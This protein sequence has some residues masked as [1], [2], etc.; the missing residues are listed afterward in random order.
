MLLK[1]KDRIYLKEDKKASDAPTSIEIAMNE[2]RD[3]LKNIDFTQ[4]DYRVTS[5]GEDEMNQEEEE[6]EDEDVVSSPR[7]SIAV[8]SDS[9]S[10]Q[11][12]QS[13][14]SLSSSSSS[15]GAG[16]GA[17]SGASTRP[18]SAVA[19]VCGGDD[20]FPKQFYDKFATP[21]TPCNALSS[22]V[23]GLVYDHVAKTFI[24]RNRGR[25]IDLGFN[26]GTIIE[27]ALYRSALYFRGIGLDADEIKEMRVMDFL[28]DDVE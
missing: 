16:S 21:L 24:L 11:R 9:F 19:S 3:S 27:E 18:S 12:K 22:A 4:S 25:R 26:S 6:E 15:S 17:T 5:D 8:T 2:I 13:T 1:I 20:E 14:D 10:G 7:A 28:T 23:I